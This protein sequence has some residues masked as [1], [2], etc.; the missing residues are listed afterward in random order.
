[1]RGGTQK[2]VD[3]ARVQM[4]ALLELGPRGTPQVSPQSS[5]SRSCP[6]AAAFILIVA[7]RSRS[8]CIRVRRSGF[9]ASASSSGLSSRSVK[10]PP[11]TGNKYLRI[12]QLPKSPNQPGG[13]A[14]SPDSGLAHPPAWLSLAPPGSGPAGCSLL[15]DFRCH[16]GILAH[17]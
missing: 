15:R 9:E 17:C 3:G 4:Q 6:R 11:T 16:G 10:E 12:Q 5:S 7:A 14:P 2:A 8:R 1:M 13:P